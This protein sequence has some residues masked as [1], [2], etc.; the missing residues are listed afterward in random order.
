MRATGAA[1][2][3]CLVRSFETRQLRT[4]T[5]QAVMGGSPLVFPGNAIVRSYFIPFSSLRWLSSG[6][7]A[8]VGAGGIPESPV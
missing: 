4:K 8:K 5:G 6:L 1:A 7:R 3:G 2:N